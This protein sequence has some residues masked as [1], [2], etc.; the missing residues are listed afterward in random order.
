MDFHHRLLTAYFTE[1]RTISEWSVLADLSEEVGVEREGFVA[2]VDEHQQSLTQ[3]VIDDHNAAIENGITGVPTIS[4]NDMF[5]IPGAQDVD[6]YD[7]WISRI[8]DRR[9]ADA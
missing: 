8:I 4:F 1:N 6:T 7:H 5:P 3:R 2:F 9:S